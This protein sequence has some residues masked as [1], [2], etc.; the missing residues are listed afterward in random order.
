MFIIITRLVQ[1]PYQQFI[2]PLQ[3]LVRNP[4]LATGPAA[5]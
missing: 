3:S 5:L 1:M 2:Y 4:S